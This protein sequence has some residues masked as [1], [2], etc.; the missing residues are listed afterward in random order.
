MELKAN[1]NFGRFESALQ[2][3]DSHTVGE[4]CRIVIGN[5]AMVKAHEI[6]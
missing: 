2:V 6:I 4:F 5:Y 3:V 1:V